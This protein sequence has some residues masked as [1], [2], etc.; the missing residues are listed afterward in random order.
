M[1]GV[2]PISSFAC[3]DSMPANL[4]KP[5]SEVAMRPKRYGKVDTTVMDASA[6]A[7]ASAV[8]YKR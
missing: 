8:K 2:E 1:E 4:P 3:P 6:A 5:P 7:D